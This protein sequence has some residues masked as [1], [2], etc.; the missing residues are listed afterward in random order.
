MTPLFSRLGAAAFVV[1]TAQAA[2]AQPDPGA[3][4]PGASAAHAQLLGGSLRHEL[5]LAGV[6]L[7]REQVVQ[8]APYC[9]DAVHETVQ[10]LADGNRIV[11][12]QPSRQ[13]R[14]GQGRTR[15]E[16]TTAGRRNVYLRD[17]VA[18]EAWMLDM[19]GK[20][21]VR[22]D[23]PMRLQAPPDGDP[24]MWDRLIGWS[25][26]LRDRF[27]PRP[28]DGAAATAMPPPPEPMRI[29]I[30]G[31]PGADLPLPPRGAM[32]PPIAFHARM[33]APRGPGVVTL[34]PGE[35]IDGLAATGKRTTW[36]IEA[37]R[38]G[39]EKPIVSVSEVWTSPD[40]GITLRSR[41][42][43]PLAGEDHFRVLTVARG[44]PDAALFR[45]PTDF[46]KVQPPAF[47]GPG[48]P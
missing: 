19:E 25:R 43:D 38:I 40:L 7:E 29:V 34:L 41:D 42:A 6:Q 31:P 45:V 44:E 10:T 37:G 11:Q 21:A 32:P 28:A 39:N 3:P 12:R 48:K 30:G 14:D 13:C 9:A 26:D 2:L 17:P 4:R 22:L 20:Q 5:F 18:Q 27:R 8:G 33:M 47:A 16:V 15:Q 46:R 36:T 24:R 23:A 35:N 1:C